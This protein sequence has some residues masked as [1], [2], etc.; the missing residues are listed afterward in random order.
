MSQRRDYSLLIFV[1]I[2]T[3]YWCNCNGSVSTLEKINKIILRFWQISCLRTNFLMNKS[4]GGGGIFIASHICMR[5]VKKTVP[6]WLSKQI[7]GR[8]AFKADVSKCGIDR[9]LIF[10]S[11]LSTIVWPRWK[12]INLMVKRAFHPQKLIWTV[13]LFSG[14]SQLW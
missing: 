12:C 2:V 6:R 4:R 3:C 1:Y 10:K 11:L 5:F 7:T 8:N 9:I 14:H 13:P